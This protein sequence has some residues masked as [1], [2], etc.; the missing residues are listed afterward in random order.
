M[1]ELSMQVAELLPA[2][3]ALNTVHNITI[4]NIADADA[5]FG[6]ARASANQTA[7]VLTNVR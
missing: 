5:I 7:V 6:G 2:R 3:E 1:T 4:I